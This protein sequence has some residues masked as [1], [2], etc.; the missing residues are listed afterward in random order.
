MGEGLV[1]EWSEVLDTMIKR[2]KSHLTELP[3]VSLLHD[4]QK[5][6]PARLKWHGAYNLEKS[7]NSLKVLEKCFNSLIIRS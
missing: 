5:G 4:K 2:W 1:L 7:L 6:W 3:W